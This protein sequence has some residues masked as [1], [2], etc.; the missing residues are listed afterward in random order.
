MSITTTF[1]IP[2]PPRLPEPGSTFGHSPVASRMAAWSNRQEGAPLGRYWETPLLSLVRG[3]T[4]RREE[5]R[6]LGREGFR[7]PRLML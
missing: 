7:I 5:Q 2:A 1:G 4:R 3:S 6:I